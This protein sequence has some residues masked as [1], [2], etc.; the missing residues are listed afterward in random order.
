VNTQTVIVRSPA[1][2]EKIAEL[3]VS[4]AADVRAA[5]ARGR[6][7]QNFWQRTSFSDRAKVLYRLRDLLLDEGDKLADVLTA[8][9]GRPGAE[10][11]GAELF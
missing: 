9:T 4:H 1:T 5:V 3:P 8:E 6:E 2:L 11:F 10:V 7:A